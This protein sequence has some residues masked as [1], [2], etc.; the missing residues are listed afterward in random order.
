VSNWLS[1]NAL[2]VITI[3]VTIV[4]SGA[5]VLQW[6]IYGKQ[7]KIM[8]DQKNLAE[9]SGD[10]Q[11]RSSRAYVLF[12]QL[13]HVRTDTGWQITPR[14]RNY[15]NTA[16]VAVRLSF[17]C[18]IDHV[19]PPERD[20][21]V[22]QEEPL[23]TI[24]PGVSVSGASLAILDSTISASVK[25]ILLYGLIQYRD[26]FTDTPDR[27]TEFRYALKLMVDDEGDERIVL[28]AYPQGNRQS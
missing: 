5:A 9:R 11:I 7:A 12:E 22:G 26:I 6:L 27:E 28:M 21:L 14:C 16:A 4:Q 25:T 24:G 13:G 2:A 15:G 1:A 3:G 18:L 10:T 17:N 19:G 23:I 20:V 8:E